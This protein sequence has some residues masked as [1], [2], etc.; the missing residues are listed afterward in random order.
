MV[1]FATGRDSPWQYLCDLFLDLRTCYCA[2]FF[3]RCFVWSLTHISAYCRW[4]WRTHFAAFR[5]REPGTVSLYHCNGACQPATVSRR[6]V[7]RHGAVLT[8]FVSL[9]RGSVRFVGLLLGISF[10][11]KGLSLRTPDR[12]AFYS[13]PKQQ[14][15]RNVVWQALAAKHRNKNISKHKIN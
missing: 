15:G 6:T 2:T 3:P 1:K 11:L 12:T 7:T 4:R 9:R 8:S 10:R 5:I 13:Q 14:T